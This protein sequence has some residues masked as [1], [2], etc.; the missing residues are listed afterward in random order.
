MSV[1]VQLRNHLLIP[2]GVPK[3][4]IE[5]VRFVGVSTTG[6]FVESSTNCAYIDVNAKQPLTFGRFCDVFPNSRVA[7][8]EDDPVVAFRMIR[9]AIL[10]QCEIGTKYEESFFASYCDY[11][12]EH[13]ARVKRLADLYSDGHEEHKH[14]NLI[15]RALL[16]L[17]Q[18]HIY[19]RDPFSPTFGFVPERMHKIDFAFWNG[20]ELIAIEIDGSSHVGSAEHV[21]KDRHLQRSGVKVIHI[22]NEEITQHGGAVIDRLLSR[23]LLRFEDNGAPLCNPLGFPF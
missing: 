6:T 14:P 9:G 10:N 16:P 17:P 8:E 11:C 7:A 2:F 5:N 1:Q 12:V 23:E 22:L 18:A 3:W 20:H 19:C 21:R 13:V 4:D 15:F